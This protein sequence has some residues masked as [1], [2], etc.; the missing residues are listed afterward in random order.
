MQFHQRMLMLQIVDAQWK[1]HLYS[2]DHLKEGIGLRAHGQRDPLVEYKKE[3][4]SMYQALMDRIDE[5]ILRW[6][7]LYQ[8]VVREE[9]AGD[10]PT[11]AARPAQAQPAVPPPQ[12]PPRA[13]LPGLGARPLPRNL[14]FNNPTEAPSA[15]AKAEPKEAK[16]GGDEVQTI[17]R[18]GKKVGRNDLCPCGSGKKYKKCHG[19]N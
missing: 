1:D 18:E 8:P 2:L 17:K 9:E 15:F 5:E 16:G 10:E 12:A 7:F 13:A 14:T 6:I 19:T 11:P 4:F 3:S